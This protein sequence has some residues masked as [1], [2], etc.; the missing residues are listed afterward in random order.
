MILGIAMSPNNDGRNVFLWMVFMGFIFVSLV[1]L[2][3]VMEVPQIWW[4]WGNWK[5]LFRWSLHYSFELQNLTFIES[6]CFLGYDFSDSEDGFLY[7]YDNHMK[8]HRNFFISLILHGPHFSLKKSPWNLPWGSSSWISWFS[9]NLGFHL[10]LRQNP[11]I[12]PLVN[13]FSNPKCPT[14]RKTHPSKY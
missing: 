9:D 1:V 7:Y 14:W 8:G 11:L 12:S 2:E 10:K 13:Y 3:R 4:G 5:W 6:R